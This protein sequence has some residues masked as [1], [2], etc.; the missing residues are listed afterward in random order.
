MLISRGAAKNYKN[1]FHRLKL[2]V[3]QVAKI[4]TTNKYE[5]FCQDEYIGE[6]KTQ[7]QNRI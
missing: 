1:I 7:L 2:S 4:G 3:P 6:S 5:C